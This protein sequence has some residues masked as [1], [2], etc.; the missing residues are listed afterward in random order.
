MTV[1]VTGSNHQIS[2][3]ISIKLRKPEALALALGCSLNQPTFHGKLSCG[4]ES[5]DLR[6][7]A[8]SKLSL[9]NLFCGLMVGRSPLQ[10]MAMINFSI[11]RTS[12]LWKD[13]TIH[14]RNRRP[15]QYCVHKSGYHQQ[16]T[17]KP[18][19][20]LL[21]QRSNAEKAKLLRCSSSD[22]NPDC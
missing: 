21:L 14:S 1:F 3:Q 22:G 5:Q 13:N 19:G 6:T 15:R 8:D 17:T 7:T 16:S 9:V 10:V 4:Q 20:L 11:N 2:R 18:G 12:W